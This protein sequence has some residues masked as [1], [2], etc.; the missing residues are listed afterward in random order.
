M[1]ANTSAAKTSG[2]TTPVD[3]DKYIVFGIDFKDFLGIGIDLS[4]LIDTLGGA[5]NFEISSCLSCLLCLFSIFILIF[6]VSKKS[7]KQGKG[8]KIPGIGTLGPQQPLVIQMPMQTQP[9]PFHDSPFP[10]DS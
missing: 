8:L 2:S 3:A 6:F 10:R 5:F 1:S 9:Y 7:G 4:G